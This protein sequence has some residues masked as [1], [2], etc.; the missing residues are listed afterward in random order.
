VAAGQAYIETTGDPILARNDSGTTTATWI[1]TQ[2][3]PVGAE[4]LYPETSGF[5]GLS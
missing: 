2:V 1:T 3:I 4:L 5:C